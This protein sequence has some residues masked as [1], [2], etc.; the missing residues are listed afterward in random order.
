MSNNGEISP[1][2]SP[3]RTLPTGESSKSLFGRI[4]WSVYGIIAVTLVIWLGFNIATGGLFLS[5]HNLSQLMVQTVVLGILACGMVLVMVAG[6]IDL[7]VGSA[8]GLTATILAYAESQLGWS[9]PAALGIT[10]LVGLLMGAWQGAWLALTRIPAFIVTLAGLTIFRGITFLMTNGQTFAPL[11]ETTSKIAN[12]TL[13]P[14]ASIGLAVIGLII[15]VGIKL[16]SNSR[17]NKEGYGKSSGKVLLGAV[18]LVILIAAVLYV[19]LAHRGLP[20]AVLI[21]AAVAVTLSFIANRTKFG[22]HLYAMGGGPAAARLAG[23]NVAKTSFFLFLGMGAIYAI[24]G[25]VLASRLGG[26]PPDPAFGMELDV[27]TAVIIGG[28]SMAGGV[29]TIRGALIG[30]VL[31]TSLTNGLD[32]MGVSSYLQFVIKGLILL[33][34]VLLDQIVKGR[35]Q[36]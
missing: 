12:G 4:D 32:L 10:L 11:E 5:P 26:A 19:S 17:A 15:Y 9:T 1:A 14:V 31:L 34:A 7:S 25:T 36:A 24:S 20:F 27:I 21:L 23:I 28:T 2:E 30:A 29:G 13:G 22:R 16:R 33:G 3:G 6:N 8:V 18:P 35:E